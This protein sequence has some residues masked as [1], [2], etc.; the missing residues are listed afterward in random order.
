MSVSTSLIETE[1]MNSI[2]DF[3]S[4][5]QDDLPPGK[6]C[7]HCNHTQIRRVIFS[8]VKQAETGFYGCY[9]CGDCGEFH[10]QIYDPTIVFQLGRRDRALSQLID[11]NLTRFSQEELNFLF[12]VVIKNFPTPEE[13]L[14]TNS[15]LQKVIFEGINI[16]HTEP[17]PVN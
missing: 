15:I 13:K 1:T 3:A 8:E 17:I 9:V 7:Q 11:R 16:F 5:F 12:S 6:S 14:K 10:K 4:S 2:A